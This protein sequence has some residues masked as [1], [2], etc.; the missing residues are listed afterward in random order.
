MIVVIFSLAVRLRYLYFFYLS[1][2][3]SGTAYHLSLYQLR[4]NIVVCPYHFVPTSGGV[5][6]T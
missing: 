1:A 2:S 6:R 4:S 5:Y 3:P